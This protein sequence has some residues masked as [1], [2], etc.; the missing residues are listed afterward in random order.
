M[1]VIWFYVFAVI[2]FL[3]GGVMW[4]LGK[5][6]VWS[7][8]LG[9]TAIGFVMAGIFH[10]LA[11]YGQT[12]DIETWS[13]QLTSGRHYARWQEYYEEAIYKN[14]PCKHT[15]YYTD[16]NGKR[17]SR[18][19][20]MSDR[21]FSHWEGRKRWHDDRYKVNSNI[22]TSHS[23]GHDD[24]Y[25]IAKSWGGVKTVPGDR[26]T[27]EHNSKMIGGDP[28]DYTTSNTGFVWPVTKLV[29]FE[30]KIKAT[31]TTFSYAKVPETIK[32][33]PYPKND[34]P[35]KSDRLLGS[36]TLVNLFAFDQM[37]ARLGPK[38]RVN[39]ILIGFGDKD[40]MMAQWQE[41][42]WVGGKKNDVVICFGGLNHSPTWARAF[43]W[44][45]K[46]ECLRQL[47]SIVL[48]KGV[49][50]DVLPL[51]EEEITRSYVLKDWKKFDYIRVP[52]PVWSVVTY[53]VVA[54]AAQTI[55]WWW[56]HANEFTKDGAPKRSFP[57]YFPS[58]RRR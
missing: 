37:N 54:L 19:A 40:S 16:S 31:P 35:F 2:P 58:Y 51:L 22:D 11:M 29:H 21:V 15:E 43:G 47:E 18:K 26:R 30:N 5:K 53:L 10:A 56:A 32:V 49:T 13:G 57:G 55:F 14:V 3:V 17:K 36:A 39:V 46:K 24:F 8:W 42:A 27:G 7:E 25:A 33:F 34:E 38:K 44:T 1:D 12:D 41:A 6:V 9:G 23:I 45:E 4:A 52:A 20:H 48:E 28:N 50:T